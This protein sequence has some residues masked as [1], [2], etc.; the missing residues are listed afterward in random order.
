[1]ENALLPSNHVNL[2]EKRVSPVVVKL[3]D[4]AIEKQVTMLAQAAA[5]AVYACCVLSAFSSLLRQGAHKGNQLPATGCR[6]DSTFR[7]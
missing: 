7:I 5:R 1:M 2:T 6:I 4:I 3:R